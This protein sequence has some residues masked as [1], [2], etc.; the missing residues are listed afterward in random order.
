ME[1]TFATSDMEAVA[2]SEARLR[3]IFGVS[4]RKACQRL[5]ELAAV[6]TLAV[7]AALPTLELRQTPGSVR[8]AVSVCPHHCI[9]F[10][11]IHNTEP[12]D[13]VDCVD[14]ASVTAIRI[15]TLGGKHDA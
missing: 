5:Y 7:A 8:F 6:E 14:L 4:T 2:L 12:V 9:G 11:P 15:L 10:E 13:A 3:K 1:L